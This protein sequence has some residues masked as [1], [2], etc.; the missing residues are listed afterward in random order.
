MSTLTAS[1][2]HH[3]EPSINIDAFLGK[4]SSLFERFAHARM[5]RQLTERQRRDTGLPVD[6]DGPYS[7]VFRNI[8]WN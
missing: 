7:E 2:A 6:L 8:G 5:L 3:H 4:L 1:L